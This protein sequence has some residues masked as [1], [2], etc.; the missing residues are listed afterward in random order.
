MLKPGALVKKET[1]IQIF[2]Y[3]SCK[4]FKNNFFT[5]NLWE[6]SFFC[7]YILTLKIARHLPKTYQIILKNVVTF[8]L[9]QKDPYNVLSKINYIVYVCSNETKF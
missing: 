8:A 2:S 6:T 5:Q 9:K 4:I 3:E 1:V 7:E